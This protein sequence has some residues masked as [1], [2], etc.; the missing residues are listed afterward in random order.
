MK[1]QQSVIQK[2]KAAIESRKV[3]AAS[4]KPII[5]KVVKPVA[6]KL[7]LSTAHSG[8]FFGS[9]V[10]SP[11]SS[12]VIAA[13]EQA[14]ANGG[15]V[16]TVAPS[17]SI[18]N[19]ST[20]QSMGLFSKKPGG[21]FFGNLLRGVA[22]AATGGILGSGANRIEIGQTK[23][24]AQLQAEAIAAQTAAAQAALSN[25]QQLGASIGGSLQ[26]QLTQQGV[27]AAASGI[28]AKYKGWII[29]GGAALLGLIVFLVTR[30]GRP[31]RR[32]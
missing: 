26:N 3:P 10:A 27:S 25:P 17:Q 7:S 11:V 19:N 24:N 21:T 30:K 22:S 8:V 1:F 23:T 28:W 14:K 29:A 13:L 20:S 9:P 2:A 15:M 18:S 5:A 6:S 12:G 31:R 4:L 16:M 32:Y